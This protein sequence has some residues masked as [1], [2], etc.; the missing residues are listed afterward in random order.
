MITSK[1]DNKSFIKKLIHLTK[2]NELLVS[3]EVMNSYPY[4]IRI[5]EYGYEFN[6]LDFYCI[7]MLFMCPAFLI[8][9]NFVLININEFTGNH[10]D[11]DDILKKLNL[12][13]N[14]ISYKK[15]LLF[16]DKEILV[17]LNFFLTF[18]KKNYNKIFNN[19]KNN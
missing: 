4:N 5:A 13:K 12:E 6:G 17:D 1:L 11:I 18:L 14:E 8:N 2:E 15:I 19:E 7:G 9:K 10:L 16:S 3:A